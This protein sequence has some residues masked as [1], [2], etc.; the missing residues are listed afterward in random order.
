MC[1]VQVKNQDTFMQGMLTSVANAT[2][3]RSALFLASIWI[4][5]EMVLRVGNVWIIYL[6]MTKRNLELPIWK[7]ILCLDSTARAFNSL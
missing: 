4:L 5:A 2:A 6:T 1:S 7:V 3:I